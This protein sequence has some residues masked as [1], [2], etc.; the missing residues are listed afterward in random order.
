M[1]NPIVLLWLLPLTILFALVLHAQNPDVNKAMEKAAKQ[2]WQDLL[3]EADKNKDGK[4]SKTE[5]FAIWKDKKTAE[6]KYTF[7]DTNKDSYITETEYVK[8]VK[9]TGTK[10]K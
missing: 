2:A 3:K 9:N 6:E 4:I 10:K 1:K 8:A 5:F 7:W